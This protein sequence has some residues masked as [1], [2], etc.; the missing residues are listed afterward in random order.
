[1]LALSIARPVKS[2]AKHSIRE[3]LVSRARIVAHKASEWSLLSQL[4]RNE[5]IVTQYG[6]NNTSVRLVNIQS[7]EFLPPRRWRFFVPRVFQIDVESFQNKCEEANNRS[8][9]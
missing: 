1:M 3:S 7:R 6:R 9:C 2:Q 5:D 4:D 8:T